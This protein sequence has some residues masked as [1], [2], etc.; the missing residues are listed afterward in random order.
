M[1]PNVVRRVLDALSASRSG[2]RDESADGSRARYTIVFPPTML[3]SNFQRPHNVLAHLA[4]DH[5]VRCLFNDW[6]IRWQE[7]EDGRLIVTKKAFRSRHHAGPFVY[8]FSI[9]DKLDYLR[10]H[11]LKPDLVVFELMDLPEEEFSAWKEKL[12]KA[13][14]RA[15]IVR[16]T[17]TAITAY[18]R[19]H[20]ATELGDKKVTTSYNGVDLARF[21]PDRSYERPPELAPIDKPILGF[22]G[23]LDWWIDW[24]LVGRLA[25]LPDY[26]VV[27]IGDTEG[28]RNKVPPE[29]LRSSIV[30]ID[31]RPVDELPAFLTHFDVALFPFVVNEMTDAVDPLK[32]WEYFAFGT[33]VLA[34]RTAFVASR[35]ELF[36]VVDDDLDRCVRAALASA[37][38]S[39]AVATRRAAAAERDWSA[40]ATEL[41]AEILA[42]LETRPRAG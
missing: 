18:L 23:N 25:E 16:T 9:P 4:R 24:D 30:W 33:P 14:E 20:Y 13:L 35:E 29:L 5:N 26:Q 8:Y 7:H 22:Y 21:D 27:V 17:N 31:R 32:V 3:W 36:Q 28:E 1:T 2:R 34:T 10:R 37:G 38:D 15:D 12:P 40:V 42:K 19:E 6:T 41:H 11:R 39:Q